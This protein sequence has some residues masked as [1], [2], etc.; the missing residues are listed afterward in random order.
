MH[1]TRMKSRTGGFVTVNQFS[2]FQRVDDFKLKAPLSL[3]LLSS[4]LSPAHAPLPRP[5]SFD[6][7]IQPT[8][9][10]LLFSFPRNDRS[11]IEC[12]RVNMGK[13]PHHQPKGQ[14]KEELF[15]EQRQFIRNNAPS[16]ELKVLARRF[17]EHFKLKTKSAAFDSLS[18]SL[19]DTGFEAQ[20]NEI[21]ASQKKACPCFM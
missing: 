15:E 20:A 18:R 10:H 7:F 6:A 13:R 19:E 5:L 17:F 9:H 1:A 14:S 21:K 8:V 16:M 3:F 4:P 12:S 2:L 11:A